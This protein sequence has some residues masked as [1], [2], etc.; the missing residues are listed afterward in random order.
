MSQ[1]LDIPAFAT[2]AEE[3][4]WWYNN[5]ELVEKEFHTAFVEGRVKQGLPVPP[6]QRT[7]PT[8]ITLDASDSKKAHAIAAKRGLKYETYLEMLVH[9]ELQQ[10]TEAVEFV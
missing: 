8:T 10:T 2:E 9:Q 1:T 4:D 5:R 6:S 7:V 3:A